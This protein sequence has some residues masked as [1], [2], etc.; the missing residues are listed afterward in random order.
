[1]QDV[2]EVIPS[3]GG[4]VIDLPALSLNFPAPHLPEVFRDN[5]VQTLK[6]LLEENVY[7]ATI[8][9]P[10]G[11]GKTTVLSH[12]ARRFPSFT[13]SIFVSSANRLS[14]DPDLLRSDV[15]GQVYWATTG[16]ILE[17]SQNAPELLKAYYSE[18]QHKAKQRKQ[19]YYF[20]VD[21]IDELSS[22]IRES[23]LKQLADILPIGIPQFRF[24]F[25]GDE[26]LYK[27]LLDRRLIMKSFPLTEF[28]IDEAK[29]LFASHEMPLDVLSEVNTVC[30]GL[31]GRLSGVLRAL[32]KGMQ[33][34]ELIQDGFSKW[35][36]LFEID[37]KQVDPGNDD[38]HRILALLAFDS[39]P[40]SIEDISSILDIAKDDVRKLIALTNF[41]NVDPDETDARFASTGLRRYAADQLKH[42]KAHVQKLLIKR[43]LA[44]PT[45][46][47]S[48]LDLPGYMED[49]AQYADLLDILTPDHILQVL[50]RGQ[51]LSRV[52]DAVKRGFRSA[53]KL[54]RD[55]DILRFGLQKSIILDLASTNIWESE[56]GALAALDREPEAMVLATNAI[57]REDRLQMLATLAHYIWLKGAI[58]PSELIDQIRLLIEN[59]DYWTLG[60]RAGSIAS[61][62]V[63][64][65][66]DLATTLL[67]KAKWA[68]GEEDLDKIFAGVTALA[69]RDVKDEQRFNQAIETM[70]KSRQSSKNGD[71]LEGVRVLAGRMSPSDVCKRSNEIGQSEARIST[72]RYWCVLNGHVPD[73][74]TVA[75]QGLR[76]ALATPSSLIDAGLL[77]DFSQALA[78]APSSE[79]VSA[80]IGMLDGLRATAERL[81]SSVDFVR[82]QLSIA[83]AEAKLDITVAEGRLTQL[84][85]YVAQISDLPSKGESYAY[86]LA[87]LKTISGFAKLTSGDSLMDECSSELESVVL[88]LAGA[89]ADHQLALGGI[90]SA[91]ATGDLAK[92]IDY[93]QVVNTEGRR[94]E[95]LVGVV[96]TLLRKSVSD[97]DP[98]SLLRAYNSIVSAENRDDALESIMERFSDVT[99]IEPQQLRALLPII[100]E[101]PKMNDSMAACR[102]LVRSLKVICTS[103]TDEYSSL[104][105]HIKTVLR[106]RWHHIDV[107][108]GR[109][110]AGYGITR[111]LA[112]VDRQEAEE[113][114]AETEAMKAEGRIAAPQGAATYISCLRLLIRAFCGMLPGRREGENDL[115]S[116]AALIEI[117]PSYGERSVLWADLCM[118]AVVAGRT[119]VAERICEDYLLPSFNKIP[120]EDASYRD[121]TLIR[122]APALYRSQP[123]ICLEELESLTPDDRDLALLSTIR[124]LLRHKVPTDPYDSGTLSGVVMTYET[125]LQVELL[126]NRLSTDWMIYDTAEEVADATQSSK[127]RYSLTRPQCEDIGRRFSAIARAKLPVGRQIT[128]KGFQIATLAQANKMSQAK[129]EAWSDLIKEAEE[130][131]NISDRSFVLQIVGLCLPNGM[132]DER[133][134]LIA[135][136]QHAIANI[137]W[138]LEQVDRLLGLADDLQGVDQ[139]LCRDLINR[140]ANTLPKSEEDTQEQRRHLVDIAFRLDEDLAKKLIDAFDDDDAK[141]VAKSQLRLLEVRKGISESKGRPDQDNA[142]KHLRAAEVHKLGSMLLRAVS[143]GRVQHFH[144]NEI[145]GYLDLAAK[146]PLSRSFPLL[147]WYIE[148]A[149]TRYSRTDQATTFLRP[150]FEACILGAQLTGQISGKSLVRLRALRSQSADLS[151]TQSLLVTPDSRDQAVTI[152]SAW[153]AKSIDGHVMIH[154]P[155]FG[156]DDLEWLQIIR[157]AKPN[158]KITVI[159]SRRHQPNPPPGE[160]LAD[161]YINVWHRLYDQ[162]PP[163]VEFA[164]IGGEKSKDSPI[165]DR[166]LIS[167]GSGL[168][169]GTSLNSLGI[170]K[171]SEI[172]EMSSSDTEQKHHEMEQYLSREKTEH[173]GE[174][175]RLTRFW[176]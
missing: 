48:I 176:L 26:S 139:L 14:Y 50:E 169:F 49:A 36:E 53:N 166:W 141:K 21:G 46:D 127:N 114:F 156:P 137:P 52:E 163:E 18:L 151:V 140:I 173:Q 64:V 75:V 158:C 84:L 71:M 79:R 62:L 92:A 170:T 11:I 57:L 105:K 90:I 130:L 5:I 37:W 150:I 154:D 23:L 104:K 144:P 93:T 135:L 99:S 148:N 142:I 73:A 175:I 134:R 168:R 29:A 98:G 94:D 17:R 120:K 143:A 159:T 44:S 174:K 74:D 103:S 65:T 131:E 160:E 55:G 31:P 7:C 123:T 9:G 124:F 164:V 72:L 32:Q 89:T 125:L 6:T 43:L 69:L 16:N 38:Q 109:I 97:I 161:V 3:L 30:R 41:L 129:K 28:S 133:S 20:V 27:D 100:S 81:G 24:L 138:K 82:L 172:S 91:L 119:E 155:F 126:T 153:F 35:P 112:T 51:T 22:T 56:V 171:D 68:T 45:S 111:D 106:T 118:R 108:W 116:I 132:T 77:A 86:F 96:E 78:G 10:E 165:H 113:I 88:T 2:R 33:P 115:K 12:F 76:L 1:M 70:T 39:K 145:R 15:A 85:V 34:S 25:A 122:I 157:T 61:K 40:H 63:C 13:I 66:P 128:H 8:E 117:L 152:L 59:L 136:A 58:V 95:V 102:A 87:A 4:T 42:K 149:V 47:T 121:S 83:R 67:R 167:N 19:L 107:G 54:G 60:R 101:I 146:Q 80:L 110:D 162:S 147:S